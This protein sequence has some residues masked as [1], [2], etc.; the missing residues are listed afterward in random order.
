MSTLDNLVN[1]MLQPAVPKMPLIEQMIRALNNEKPPQFKVPAQKY[2]F[3]TG[4]HG[5]VY[6]YSE[7]SVVISYLVADSIYSDVTVS[8]D[9]FRVIL[10]GLAVCIRQQ[11]W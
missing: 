11:K 1:E 3:K 10:E 7:Q 8:F 5:I 9:T 2:T 6:N 4:Q